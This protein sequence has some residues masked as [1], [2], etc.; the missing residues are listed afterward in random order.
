MRVPVLARISVLIA[1]AAFVTAGTAAA[2]IGQG[3]GLLVFNGGYVTGSSAISGENI[4]GGIISFAYEKL[5]W[6]SP[7]S[8][9]FS[10]AYTSVDGDSGSGSN[11]VRTSANSVPM[12][13]GGKYWLGKSK[14]QGYL[15]VAL[16]LYFSWLDK[17]Y[18]ET[19]D[20]YSSIETTGMG[21]GIPIGGTFSIGKTVFINANY[22]LNWLWDNEIL[23]DD[24]LHAFNLGI[25]FK[26]GK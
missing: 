5:D 2:Q 4:D 18:V 12:Y 7:F 11:R 13:F 19:G 10:I 6:S 20:S 24:L 17:E 22:T 26:L 16:G 21:L 9:G 3:D 25:G 1:A 14:V 8:F 23:K 15:G